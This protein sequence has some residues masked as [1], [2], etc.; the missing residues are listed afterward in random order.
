MTQPISA[1]SVQRRSRKAQ[2]ARSLSGD[3]PPGMSIDRKNNDGN[4]EPGNCTWATRQ[5]QRRNRRDVKRYEVRGRSMT[6]VEWSAESG[7][8]LA[9]IWLRLKKG[10]ETEAAIFTPP[11]P[12]RLRGKGIAFGDERG[13][14]WSGPKEARAA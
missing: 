10:W 2:S 11:I 8:A 4:Y 9:T 13:I 7:V 5:E 6:L 3:P 14:Q 1:Q 12:Q